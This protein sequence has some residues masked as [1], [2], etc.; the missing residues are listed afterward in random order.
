MLPLIRRLPAELSAGPV[1][2]PFLDR[3]DSAGVVLIC[4][5]G[6]QNHFFGQQARA[7]W[8]EKLLWCPVWDE[9]DLLGRRRVSDS[10]NRLR[11]KF[12]GNG[13]HYHWLRR[14]LLN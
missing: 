3:L 12:L 4:H 7:A 8:A 1:F 6:G 10:C 9:A 2:G 13:L 5:Q 11:G 14:Y